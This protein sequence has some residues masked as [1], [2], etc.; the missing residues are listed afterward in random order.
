[1]LSAFD[2]HYHEY[3]H[4][5]P[6]E[7]PN[8]GQICPKNIPKFQQFE[9]GQVYTV[10]LDGQTLINVKEGQTIDI[11]SKV[12]VHVLSPCEFSLKLRDSQLSGVPNPQELGRQLDSSPELRFGAHDGKVLGVCPV[13]EE[14]VWTLNIKK[15]ILSAMQLTTK[16]L[17]TTSTVEEVDFSGHCTTTY[18]PLSGES[19]PLNVLLEK[20]KNL[21]KCHLRRKNIAGFQSKSLT[22]LTEFLR[23]N[24][25]ILKSNQRCLQEIKSGHL[26]SVRCTE[27]QRLSF[28][29]DNIVVSTLNLRFGGKSPAPAPVSPGPVAQNAETLLMSRLTFILTNIYINT[30]FK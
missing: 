20:T 22:L 1:M 25:P 13:P 3:H 12:D 30:N 19:D 26:F 11:K 6:I 8:C 15:A 28:Q 21:N 17:T 7:Q 5:H 27:E 10:E 2:H 4:H 18:R 14:Q 29:S 16:D 9:L 23:E 24:L